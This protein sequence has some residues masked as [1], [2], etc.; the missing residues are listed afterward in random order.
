MNE[1][2]NNKKWYFFWLALVAVVIAVIVRLLHH[3]DAV[4]LFWTILLIPLLLLA[5]WPITMVAGLILMFILRLWKTIRNKIKIRNIKSKAWRIIDNIGTIRLKEEEEFSYTVWKS[6][7][8][9]EIQKEIQ[10]IQ[11]I[12]EA[13]LKFKSNNDNEEKHLCWYL[14]SLDQFVNDTIEARAKRALKPK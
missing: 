12:Q 14:D 8:N 4:N 5:L 7:E 9:K 11:E 13:L 10:E 1:F 2:L 3:F 6:I